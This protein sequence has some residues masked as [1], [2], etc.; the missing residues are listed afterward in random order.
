MDYTNDEDNKDARAQPPKSMPCHFSNH[1]VAYCL[2][3]L[4]QKEY[5]SKLW[6]VAVVQRSVITTV[7][8]HP[9][10][11]AGDLYRVYIYQ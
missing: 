8:K 10:K 2:A 7:I 5:Y 9:L 1:F 4:I 6:G 3:G 11:A